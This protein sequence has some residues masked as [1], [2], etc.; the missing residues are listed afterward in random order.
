MAAGFPVVVVVHE[1]LPHEMNCR[2]TPRAVMRGLG[3]VCWLVVCLHI[4]SRFTRPERFSAPYSA[5]SEHGAGLVI[6][7]NISKPFMGYVHCG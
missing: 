5:N 7:M 2:S 6:F 3:Q 1:F 4:P